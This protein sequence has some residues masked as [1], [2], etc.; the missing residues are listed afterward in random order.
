MQRPGNL[1]SDSS[2]VQ[3][4]L[5]FVRE[6][7]GRAN[8]IQIADTIFR[9]SNATEELAKALVTDLIR[10]DPRFIIEGKHLSIK[11]DTVDAQPLNEVDFVVMDVEAISGRA[12][13]KRVIE[14]GA[15][16]VRAGEITDEYQTLLNP[17]LP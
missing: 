7:D 2:M 14:I 10:N 4:T 3:E 1:I 9:I 6:R 17:E 8:F 15:C 16:R 12:L 11:E 5:D 13:P